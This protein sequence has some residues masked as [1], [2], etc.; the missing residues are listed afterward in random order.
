[1][2]KI[3]IVKESR[4]FDR[5]INN[6]SPFRYKNFLLYIERKQENYRFGISVSKHI[7]NAVGRNKIKRQIR[8]I[9]SDYKFQPDFNCII[10]ARKS[11]LGTSYLEMK[12]QLEFCFKKLNMLKE[13]EKDEK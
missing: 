10:I 7:C 9:I 3:N 4:D 8:N 12:Q 1:M 2:K 11:I 13:G 6:F 5:L